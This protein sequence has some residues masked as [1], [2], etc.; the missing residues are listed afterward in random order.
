MRR[1]NKFTRRKKLEKRTVRD[2]ELFGKLSIID[3]INVI[4]KEGFFTNPR[5][6]P[7]LIILKSIHKIFY[8]YR[9]LK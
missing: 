9:I 3:D 7:F 4:E 5:S 8:K 6:Q 2:S 1:N